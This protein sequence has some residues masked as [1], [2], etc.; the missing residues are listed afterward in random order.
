MVFGSSGLLDLG[1]VTL[2]AVALADYFKWRAKADKGFTWVALSGMFFLFAG[3]FVEVNVLSAQLG[4]GWTW[5]ANVF[6]ILGW[7]FALI[8]T[9]FIGYETLIE[10]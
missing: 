2:L 1:I 4:P 3:S 8:G 5:L 7:L 9:I 10:K 6:E